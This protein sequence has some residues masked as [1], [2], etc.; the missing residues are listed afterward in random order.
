MDR[1]R[2]AGSAGGFAVGGEGYVESAAGAAAG[3]YVVAFDPVVDDVGA[4]AQEGGDFVDSELVGRL[5]VGGVGLVEMCGAS[6]AWAAGDFDFGAE[7]YAPLVV[8]ASAGDQP[9]SVD[10]VDDGAVA[11]AES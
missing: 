5:G 8:E 3:V 2:D 1:C 7:G 11:D 6:D 10:P 9:A 4:D